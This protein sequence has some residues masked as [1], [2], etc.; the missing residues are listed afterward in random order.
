MNQLVESRPAILSQVYEQLVAALFHTAKTCSD[1]AQTA[2]NP[3]PC[4]APPSFAV[5]AQ[6]RDL[7]HMALVTIS[8]VARGFTR[9][10]V[11]TPQF[12]EQMLQCVYA[13]LALYKDEPEW[14]VSADPVCYSLLL[15]FYLY[16]PLH[17]RFVLLDYALD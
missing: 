2:L 5:L 4:Q 9:K 8:T 1:F 12:A 6:L 17:F 10:L 3:T 13:S 16:S 14:L 7:R 11:K 15:H